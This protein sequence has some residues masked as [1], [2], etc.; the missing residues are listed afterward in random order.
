MKL[1]LDT[2]ALLWWFDDYTKLSQDAFR[3]IENIENE[4]F[5]SAAT[6]WEIAIKK[7]IGKLEAPDNFEEELTRHDF[8]ALGIDISHTLALID[9]PFYHKDPFD[10]LIIAQA[11]IKGLTIVTCDKKFKQYNIPLITA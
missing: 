11:Q 7:S 10:R 4:I 5:V 1:L 3:A 8:T 6:S 9:L 2:H